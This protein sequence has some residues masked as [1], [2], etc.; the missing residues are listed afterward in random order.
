M[1]S[2]A[3]IILPLALATGPSAH[4]ADVRIAPAHFRHGCLT[5]NRLESAFPPSVPL[6]LSCHGAG[7]FIN[8]LGPGEDARR[9]ELGSDIFPLKWESPKVRPED[10]GSYLYPWRV[11]RTVFYCT[12]GHAIA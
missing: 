1:D 4:A 3:H 11:T 6:L 2:L 5:G 12:T 9:G 8:I 10:P 7:T